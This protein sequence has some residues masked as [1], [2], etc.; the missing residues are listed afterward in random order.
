MLNERLKGSMLLVV[1]LAIIICVAVYI[2]SQ[3]EKT[4]VINKFND[5]DGDEYEGTLNYI[6]DKGAA[7]NYKGKYPAYVKDPKK[8]TLFKAIE[9][10]NLLK[11]EF[12]ADGAKTL[13]KTD[14]FLRKGGQIKLVN[15]SLIKPIT[16]RGHSFVE[17]TSGLFVRLDKLTLV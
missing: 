16:L 9:Q 17:S 3:K 8:N 6:G 13:I 7:E 2:Y 11:Y 4:T 12:N 15:D 5:Y 1:V 14:R 10:A